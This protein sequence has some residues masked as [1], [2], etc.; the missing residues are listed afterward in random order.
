MSS[1]D[2]EKNSLSNKFIYLDEIYY[3]FKEGISLYDTKY[4]A[5]YNTIYYSG[6]SFKLWWSSLSNGVCGSKIYIDGKKYGGNGQN[7]GSIPITKDEQTIK[8][9]AIIDYG[10]LCGGRANSEEISVKIIK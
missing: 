5:S 7:S 4:Y 2:Y 8:F 1:K 6:D 10:V 3:K 9:K